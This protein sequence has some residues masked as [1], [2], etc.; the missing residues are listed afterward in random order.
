MFRSRFE[1]RQLRRIRKLFELSD[2]LS[3]HSFLILVKKTSVRKS[4]WKKNEEYQREKI[5]NSQEFEIFD[6]DIHNRTA[7]LL[8]A[9]SAI[10]EQ[11]E[12]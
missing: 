9:M 4:I 11:N 3:L 12:F 1:S 6:G 10:H 7:D 5:S 8:N 2:N